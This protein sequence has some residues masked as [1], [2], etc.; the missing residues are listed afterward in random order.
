MDFSVRFYNVL[1]VMWIP[2]HR[3]KCNNSDRIFGSYQLTTKSSKLSAA[4]KLP[5]KIARCST[6]SLST[7][8]GSQ[9]HIS[10]F[11]FVE[12]LVTNLKRELLMIKQ[13]YCFENIFMILFIY[14]KTRLGEWKHLWLS[15]FV[16][17]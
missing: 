10:H 11:R 14:K 7:P 12:P 6:G 9:M 4:E 17:N 1:N 15:Y 2:R 5:R 3:K 13:E 16:N 8:T